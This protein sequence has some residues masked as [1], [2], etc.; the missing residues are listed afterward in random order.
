MVMLQELIESQTSGKPAEEIAHLIL[1]F[2]P[3]KT[4]DTKSMKFLEKFPNLKSLS[5]VEAEIDTIE[6][7]PI[8]CKIEN[9]NLADNLIHRGLE[10]L[11]H[12]E[13]LQRLSL[14]GNPIKDLESLRPLNA[15]SNLRTVDLSDT[16]L[17]LESHEN[18][19]PFTREDI[20]SVLKNVTNLIVTDKY[21]EF[22]EDEGA[23]ESSEDDEGLRRIDI[24]DWYHGLNGDSEDD[25]GSDTFVPKDDV[26]EDEFEYF[27]DEDDADEFE[28]A[29]P[30][31]PDRIHHVKNDTDTL[32]PGYK[33]DTPPVDYLEETNVVGG[34]THPRPVGTIEEEDKL[35]SHPKKPKLN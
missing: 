34:V 35:E 19:P 15:L 30:P 14:A 4:L 13:N 31:K 8:G 25:E 5:V 1:D 22:V 23:E 27:E 21:T 2:A 24:A 9:L 10:N 20:Q 32:I 7:F 26:E 29:C 16:P 3:I 12:V 11:R 17:V 18:P 28:E 6:E 33:S